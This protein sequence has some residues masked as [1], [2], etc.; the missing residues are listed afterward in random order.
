M[1]IYEYQCQKCGNAME[2]LQKISDAPLTECPQCG[3]PELRK[4]ISA[5]A[6]RLKGGGWYETDFKTGS[7]KNLHGAPDS[8][9]A[10]DKPAA[11]DK[12]GSG[13]SESNTSA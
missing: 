10:S 8:A 3:A 4:K 12:S 9:A 13:G 6:F 2:V 1:P 7:K 5:A 11:S